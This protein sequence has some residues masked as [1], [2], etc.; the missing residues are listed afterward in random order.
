[1]QLRLDQFEHRGELREQQDAPAFDEQFVEHFQQAGELAGSCPAGGAL[2]QAR[3]AADLAQLE[4]RIEDDEVAGLQALALDFLANLP[5]HRQPHGFVE[6]ALRLAQL[7]PVGDL[8]LRRQFGGDLFLFSA[9]QEG[10]DP[11][12]EVRQPLAVVEFLDGRAVEPGE[13]A[14]RAEPA[15][16]QQVE[17][18]PQ[19]AQVVFQRRAGHAQAL[20][21]LQS[22][23]GHGGLA[24][25]GLD[26]LRLV[27][28]QQVQRL[29]AQ[30][31]DIPRQQGVGGEDQV[32]ALQI[33]EIAMPPRSVQGQHAQAGS[34][35]CGF[36]LPVGDQAG[37]HQH[38]CRV[39][40]P[41]RFF[42]HKDVGQRLQGLAQAHVVAEDAAD[43]Q[44]AQGLHPAQAFQL[45]GAQRRLQA[46]RRGARLGT[47]VAQPPG[48]GAQVFAALPFQW[49]FFQGAEAGGVGNAQTQGDIPAGA[50]MQFAK[51]GEDGP[52]PGE[53][54]LDMDRLA[55]C[56][57]RHGDAAARLRCAVLQQS[58]MGADGADEYRQQADPPPV[59]EDAEFEIEPVVPR[60]FLDLGEPAVHRRDLHGGFLRRRNP[61][62]WL[63]DWRC[64]G[65]AGGG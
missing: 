35:A 25:G 38:Q 55:L 56:I 15:G 27:E 61:G 24:G 9:Q 36:V 23:G 32:V 41:T 31:F 37:G 22:A 53:G 16:H 11:R 51:G 64:R 33:G 29:L 39:I 2:Q 40:Q 19:L 65:R 12:I 4:Q 49:Q 6:V 42:L 26:V 63:D 13:L 3:I 45:V 59:D 48:E 47:V 14:A 50:H 18:R 10:F 46:G 5:V 62:G 1:M 7:D 8:A 52:Q 57:E 44:F 30:D 58:G 60:M 34:E 20:A 28:D 43:A 54:Q 21:R 17:Q